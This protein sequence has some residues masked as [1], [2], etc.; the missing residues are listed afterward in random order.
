M[1]RIL[2]IL[3]MLI[4]VGPACSAPA[5]PTEAPP[6]EAAAPEPVA[7]AT[8]VPTTE[9]VASEPAILSEVENNV[10]VRAKNEADWKIVT[11]VELVSDGASVRTQ[12]DST[13]R[14]DL[15]NGNVLL[16]GP[17]TIFELSNFD[18]QNWAILLEQGGVILEVTAEH[19]GRS[20]ISTPIGIA[21]P[22]GSILGIKF[23]PETEIMN[24]G[25]FEGSCAAAQREFHMD[26]DFNILTINSLLANSEEHFL[27]PDKTQLSIEK[28]TDG[29][30][31]VSEIKALDLGDNKI[32]DIMDGNDRG[33]LRDLL[34]NLGDNSGE[35]TI[36]P[37]NVATTG[38]NT[39]IID[40]ACDIFQGAQFSHVYGEFLPGA[41]LAVNIK[42]P[43]SVAWQDLDY[44][45]KIGDVET[46]ACAPLEG[47]NTRLSCKIKLPSE[48]ISTYKHHLS[49]HQDGCEEPLYTKGP[50]SL[51]VPEPSDEPK[52]EGEEDTNS[53]DAYAPDQIAC[54]SHGGIWDLVFF[55]CTCP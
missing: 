51:P 38:E 37:S 40:S 54:E 30:P 10:A 44:K 23:V 33:V 53:C 27:L 13:A 35:S 14:L 22:T 2:I 3:G 50:L 24:I 12:A 48:Y 7:Q 47:N 19:L 20:V 16:I 4:L 42:M 15:P 11:A 32:G 41:P 25:C 46:E 55:S 36:D 17:D 52:D 1:K 43:A 9:V 31:T 29:E 28:K 26:D 8:A 34:I 18:G 21:W 39:M 49:L 6:I 5:Q 45:M